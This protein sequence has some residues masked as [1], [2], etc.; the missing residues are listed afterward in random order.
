MKLATADATTIAAAAV[1]QSVRRMQIEC[2][3][4]SGGKNGN[5]EEWETTKINAYFQC[6]AIGANNSGGGCG[7]GRRS[8]DWLPALSSAHLLIHALLC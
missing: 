8:L 7:G 3:E 2:I 5:E 4:G 1:F 6:L